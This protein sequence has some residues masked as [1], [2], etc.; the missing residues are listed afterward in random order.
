MDVKMTFLGRSR[1]GRWV[2][3]RD[4]TR[5]LRQK[6][7]TENDT[8]WQLSEWPGLSEGVVILMM[9]ADARC[10]LLDTGPLKIS[11]LLR[12][13]PTLNDVQGTNAQAL[14]LR[15]QQE[16]LVCLQATQEDDPWLV[17]LTETYVGKIC[18]LND[19]LERHKLYRV[20]NIAYWT[21]N[22]TRFANWEATL[23]AGRWSPFILWHRVNLPSLMKTLSWVL[24]AHVWLSPKYW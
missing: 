14:K 4:S 3:C 6:S 10:G 23:E 12:K 9:K 5:G 13:V 21:S 18:F 20:S 1:S 22:K 15:Q 19:I 11:G 24:K 2:V 16:D 8:Q 7:Q 17:F